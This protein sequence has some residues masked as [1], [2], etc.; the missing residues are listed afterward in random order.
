M[1][2]ADST[3]AVIF[4]TVVERVADFNDNGCTSVGTDSAELF[5]LVC[6][7]PGRNFFNKLH[8]SVLIEHQKYTGCYLRLK[9][10]YRALEQSV[11]RP[12]SSN[13][14]ISVHQ[15]MGIRYSS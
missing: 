1:M 4:E 13:M 9:T 10:F 3:D 12:V 6:W 15:F 7:R 14:D 2:Y 8:F 11:N 5:F